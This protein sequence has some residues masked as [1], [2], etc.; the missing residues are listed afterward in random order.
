ML[1]LRNFL[2]KDWYYH[3]QKRVQLINGLLLMI[4]YHQ[5]QPH[6]LG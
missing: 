6:I 5:I 1:E 3:I 4:K 2:K